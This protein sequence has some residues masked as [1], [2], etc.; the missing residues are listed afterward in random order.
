LCY[1]KGVLELDDS[2]KRSLDKAFRET[3][4]SKSAKIREF[5]SQ[6][7]GVKLKEDEH[8][9]G[10]LA[11]AHENAMKEKKRGKASFDFLCLRCH[12]RIEDARYYFQCQACSTALIDYKIC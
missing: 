4:I 10:D 3:L 8:F 11:D 7:F 12:K 5:Y 9:L 1:G 6:T 2:I